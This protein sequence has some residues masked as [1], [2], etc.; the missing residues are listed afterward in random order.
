MCVHYTIL[1][2]QI[3]RQHASPRDEEGDGDGKEKYDS[4][5]VGEAGVAEGVSEYEKLQTPDGTEERRY[6]GEETKY[7]QYADKELDTHDTCEH[8]GPPRKEGDIEGG[9]DVSPFRV[10]TQSEVT[11]DHAN[12]NAE[13]GV[14][15]ESEE[16]NR[17]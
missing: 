4:E 5:A 11:P 12:N 15:E 9:D 6:L 14:S 1:N 3:K 10:M 7:K 17:D 2:R 16:L 8:D 13:N